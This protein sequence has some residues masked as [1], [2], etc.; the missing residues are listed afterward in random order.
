MG[1][2]VDERYTEVVEADSAEDA[3]SQVLAWG[4]YRIDVDVEVLGEADPSEP[5]TIPTEDWAELENE[6]HN[7]RIVAAEREAAEVPD[8]SAISEAD[9]SE[10]FTLPPVTPSSDVCPECGENCG[11]GDAIINQYHNGPVEPKEEQ[12]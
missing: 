11:E 5:V 2:V 3:K 7:P 10:I 8:P 1:T 9:L 12:G 4:E 6:I